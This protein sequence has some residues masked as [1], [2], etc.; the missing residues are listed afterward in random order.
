MRTHELSNLT[1]EAEFEKSSKVNVDVNF[2]IDFLKIS[3]F[4]LKVIISAQEE[5]VRF[6]LVSSYYL[7][8]SISIDL[9]I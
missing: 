3:L 6:Y 7:S 9:S 5:V 1:A 2:D 4:K 8:F